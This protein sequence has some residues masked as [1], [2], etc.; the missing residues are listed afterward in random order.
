[1][2]ITRHNYEEY[3][4]LYVDNELNV[5]QRKAVE[6]F[7]QENPDLR[8]ELTMLQEAVLPADDQIMFSNKESLLK[9]TTAPN[10]VNE[11]NYEEYFVLYGDDELTNEQKDQVEQFVYRNPQHQVTFE[12]MQQVRLMPDMS[13]VFPDKYALYRTEEDDKAVPVIRMR[14]WRM[15]AAAA[16]LLFIGGM[17]WYLSTRDITPVTD[18]QMA[19]NDTNNTKAV[20]QTQKQPEESTPVIRGNKIPEQAPEVAVAPEKKEKSNNGQQKPVITLPVTPKKTDD[21]VTVDAPKEKVKNN[22]AQSNIR[23]VPNVTHTEDVA[24]V[25]VEPKKAVEAQKINP[26]IATAPTKEDVASNEMSARELREK[27]RAE[28]ESVED[29]EDLN[30]DA[31]ASNDN[32]KNKMR[33]FFRKVSRVFDKATNLE[34]EGKEKSGIRIASFEIALK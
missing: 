2:N 3:F 16:V 7:L 30:A 15:A 14:W 27:F 10:P 4:L 13:V 31:Y 9:T 5:T 1:M 20:E 25:N 34:P 28:K 6:T 23:I 33:G 11:T 22:A 18:Q 24:V 19:A 21:I 32:K 12:V 8:S 17:S 26:N 29:I